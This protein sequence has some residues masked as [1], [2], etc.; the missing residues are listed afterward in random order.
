MK[1]FLQLMSMLT[2][3]FADV[4]EGVHILCLKLLANFMFIIMFRQIVKVQHLVN[5]MIF[6]IFHIVVVI[7]QLMT[8]ATES[9]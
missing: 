4:T 7:P 9:F 3:K 8:F 5:I 6:M 1:V 2:K